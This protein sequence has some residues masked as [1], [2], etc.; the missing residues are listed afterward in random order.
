MLFHEDFC[1]RAL[2]ISGTCNEETTFALL[3]VYILLCLVWSD[4]SAS[5]IEENKVRYSSSAI[6]KAAK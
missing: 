2:L 4:G 1:S 3:V 5:L 6:D